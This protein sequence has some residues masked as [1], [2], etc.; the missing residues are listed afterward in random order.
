LTSDEADPGARSNIKTKLH[1]ETAVDLV[2]FAAR[3][4]ELL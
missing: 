1:L 2:R 4:A 3:W